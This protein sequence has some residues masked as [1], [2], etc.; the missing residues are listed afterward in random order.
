MSEDAERPFGVTHKAPEPWTP[1]WAR[2][3][4]LERCAEHVFPAS[5]S[6]ARPAVADY[7]RLPARSEEEWRLGPLCVASTLVEGRCR[8]CRERGKDAGPVHRDLRAAREP[9]PTLFE[10][11]AEPQPEPPP[12]PQRWGVFRTE[13]RS[14]G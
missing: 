3:A 12:E 14:R 7:L 9:A 13:P 2:G 1:P 11:A 5:E 8:G 4:R 6:P 10:V